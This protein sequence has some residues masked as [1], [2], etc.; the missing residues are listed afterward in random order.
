MLNEGKGDSV[1]FNL[2]DNPTITIA[3][4]ENQTNELGIELQARPTCTQS[5]QE[6]KKPRKIFGLHANYIYTRE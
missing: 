3:D 4:H 2:S 6:K 5:Q 1:I